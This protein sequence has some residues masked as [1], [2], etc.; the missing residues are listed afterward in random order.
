MKYKGNMGEINMDCN[1]KVS[2]VM[3]VYNVE[4]YI[5]E[6]LDSLISQTL[7]EI[8]IICVDDG[9]TDGTLNLLYKY[10]KSDTRVKVIQQQNQYAGVARNNGMKH[11]VGEY[12][13]F[14]DSDDFF[15]K[16]MLEKMYN[17]AKRTE[18]DLVLCGGQVFDDATKETKPAPWFLKTKILP[19]ELPFSYRDTDGQL[20]NA[21]S[22][23]PWTKMF[24]KEFVDKSGIQFQPFQNSND[25]YFIFVMVCTSERISY[26]DEALVNY[27]RG[28]STNL[29]SKKHKAP[30]CFLEAYYS[31]YNTLVE[32]NVYDYIKK[33]FRSAVI[34]GCLYNYD[35]YNYSD[36]VSRQKLL[37]AFQEDKFS[38]LQLFSGEK[39][40]YIDWNKVCRLKGLIEGFGWKKNLEEIRKNVETRCVKERSAD[41]VPK[42]SVI[43]PC[44]N[45]ENYVEDC[46]KSILNQTL[47]EIEVIC[48]NDGSTDSTEDMLLKVAQNDSRVAVYTQKN[49]GQ[50]A[51]RNQAVKKATGQYLYFM[52]SDDL[53]EKEALKELYSLSDEKRLDVLYFDGTTFYESVELETEKS[54]YK[55]YYQRKFD[56][57]GVEDGISMMVEMKKNAEYRQSP[58]L[59][60]I[61]RE[62]FV[63]KE[64][65]YLPGVWHEDNSFTFKTMLMA[66]KV[67]HIPVT[68]FKRRVRANSVMTSDKKFIHSYGLFYNYFNM[69]NM[70]Q[71]VEISIEQ[72][73]VIMKVIEGV[74]N[75]ARK[76]YRMLEDE[77][78]YKYQ[79]LEGIEKSLFYNWVIYSKYD[80]DEH[81][82]NE[83]KLKEKIKKLVEQQKKTND[84]L[85]KNEQILE[86]KINR[87]KKEQKKAKV[88][89]KNIKRSRSYKLAVIIRKPF[90]WIKNI[91]KKWKK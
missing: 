55:G 50:G 77:E 46:L 30:L 38:E 41:I 78:K 40:E 51:A 44:Y 79:C 76:K 19:K 6:C 2:V 9:S 90:I 74:L 39:E 12:I 59:Q 56:Y 83:K 31:A 22:P 87:L 26:V 3:P 57:S 33:G 18:A 82:K 58:C 70:V 54:S 48:V 72:E 62:Y 47:Y 84:N 81:V 67:A 28:M 16:T 10:E 42:V 11:A 8:E 52:D 71:N 85:K 32:K 15:E 80:V 5:E 21:I 34:S 86:A 23:A 91:K 53:L 65:W 37:E 73:N 13:L 68:Y 45:V 14:L 88:E 36:V 69:V 4:N 64:L 27:R 20:L 49:A 17:E 63:E 24:K 89:L 75:E 60:F 61:R 25:V 35:S 29:Q 1:V 66:E 43:I 7:K